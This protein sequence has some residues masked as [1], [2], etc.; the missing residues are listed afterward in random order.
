MSNF[1]RTAA[2]MI[3]AI[4]A[5]CAVFGQS[6]A[7]QTN[8]QRYRAAA[9]YSRKNM[10]LSVLIMKG[11]KVVFEEYQNGHNADRP[12][13]LASGTKSFS[14][15]MCAAAIEDGLITSFDE[16]VSDTI[17][18]WIADKRRSQITIRQLL[19]LTSGI[20]AGEIGRVPSYAEAVTKSS[21]YEPGANFEY[22][23]VPFQV[24][25]ELMTRKLKRTNETVYD[26][27]NRRILKPIGLN[28][29]FWRKDKGQPLLPQ[30]AALTA[31]EWIKFG[32]LLKN[33]GK[34][35][36]K[37]IVRENL[38][39]ELRIGSKANPAYGITFWLNHSGAGPAGTRREAIVD[40]SAKDI[41]GGVKDLFMAAG[42]ANQRLYIIPLL[43]LV[44]VRQ[45]QMGEWDDSEFITRLLFGR[46]SK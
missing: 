39:N 26:Y 12:W 6:A 30:G 19:S 2:L 11:D 3:I 23:P 9:D 27:L 18:E 46:P 10:G 7:T 43:D 34:W 17:T 36:G 41:A 15:V 40:I 16:K 21:K 1:L 35:N 8:E 4:N 5:G 25:G 37:Q 45:G 33:G 42:A 32:Q 28:V 29:A 31:R 24:F 13:I 44:V 14:G 20:D 22:G 38:L